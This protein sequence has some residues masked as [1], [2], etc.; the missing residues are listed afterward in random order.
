M[1]YFIQNVLTN[2]FR[3]IFRP[4]S[5]LRYYKRTNVVNRDTIAP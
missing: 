4:I 2:M 5:G 3:P 1:M